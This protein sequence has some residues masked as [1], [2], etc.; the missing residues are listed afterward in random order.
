M[1]I[2]VEVI[3]AGGVKQA[4][5]GHLQQGELRLVDD[6]FGRFGIANGWFRHVPAEGEELVPTG[7]LGAADGHNPETWEPGMPRIS[8]T[9]KPDTG[10]IAAK[11]KK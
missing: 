3:V 6:K 7:E 8:K 1:D 10:R 4:P 11:S 9:I 2:K 5:Y